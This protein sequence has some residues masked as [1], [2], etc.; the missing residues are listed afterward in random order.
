MPKRIII[1]EDNES[2]RESYV[3]CFRLLK[4]DLEIEAVSSG[5]ELLERMKNK[6]YDLVMTDNDLGNGIN[7]FEVIT[8]IRESNKTI[9]ILMVSGTEGIIEKFAVQSGATGYLVKKNMSL[10]KIKEEIIDA[11]LR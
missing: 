9:P 6:R 1:A 7:G 11:Y 10:G 4:G 2:L 5:E 3:E 8:R